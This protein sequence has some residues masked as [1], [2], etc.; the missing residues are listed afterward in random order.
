MPAA[1]TAGC[2]ARHP[3]GPPPARPRGGDGTSGAARGRRR[4]AGLPARRR[5][6]QRGR[7]AARGSGRPARRARPTRP[8]AGRYPGRGPTA[9]PAPPSGPGQRG[10]G[11]QPDRPGGTDRRGR[12]PEPGAPYRPRSR[13]GCPGDRPG[14][15]RVGGATRRPG[16]PGGTR[17]GLPVLARGRARPAARAGRAGDRGGRPHRLRVT[18]GLLGTPGR[19]RGSRSSTRRR[20]RP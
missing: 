19:G 8:V 16:R 4:R 14:V 15:A 1:A 17:T 20:P 18:A 10:R 5:G 6:D 9:R 2:A 11:E 12:R 3:R 7:R 13:P